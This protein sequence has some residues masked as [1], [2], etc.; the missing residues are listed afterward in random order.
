MDSPEIALWYQKE[1]CSLKVFH[2]FISSI[3]RFFSVVSHSSSFLAVFAWNGFHPKQS[4][5]S[6]VT[7]AFL[8]T[9]G[10][11]LKKLSTRHLSFRSTTRRQ[12]LHNFGCLW[13][14]EQHCLASKAP[15][16]LEEAL[17]E[18]SHWEKAS[19]RGGNWGEMSSP[20][21]IWLRS[22][23]WLANK[24]CLAIHNKGP[25]SG[26]ITKVYWACIS[27]EQ[28]SEYPDIDRNTRRNSLR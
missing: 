5:Q 18:K 10:G 6:C 19:A 4:N 13:C 7:S 14:H 8:V 9:P 21:E 20:K 28:I 15:T 11:H 22:P 17:L 2:L 26:H 25:I 23:K 27:L 24:P 1:L 16:A 12:A 3:V